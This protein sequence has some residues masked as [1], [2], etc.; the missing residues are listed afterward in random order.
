MANSRSNASGGEA[1][2]KKC[3]KTWQGINSLMADG[4][5]SAIATPIIKVGLFGIA[6]ATAALS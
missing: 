5:L 6:D 2:G 4:Q 3:I 1:Q